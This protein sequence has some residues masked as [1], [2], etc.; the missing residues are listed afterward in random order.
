MNTGKKAFLSLL[1]G[2]SLLLPEVAGA[3]EPTTAP[4]GPRTEAQDG[5][6]GKK[7]KKD[8]DCPGNK[9]NR[10]KVARAR[11]KNHTALL[12]IPRVVVSPAWVS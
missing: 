5:I 8:C 3:T 12:V 4:D 10:R 6:F 9:K 7:K 1:L 2:V 11:R